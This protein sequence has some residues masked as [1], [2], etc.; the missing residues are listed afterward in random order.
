LRKGMSFFY[1]FVITATLFV[2]YLGSEIVSVMAENTPVKRAHCIILDAGH[3]GVDGGT[4]SCDGKLESA[5]NLEITLRLNS[6][7]NF[8][9]HETVMIRTSDVSV[10]TKGETIA[11]KKVSDLRERVRIVNETKNAVLL[12]IHQNYFSDSRYRGAQVFYADTDGSRELA[13]FLQSNLI[14]TVNPGST[15]MSKKSSGIYLMEHIRQ[16]G[17]LI[18]CGFLS[19]AEESYKLSTPEYQKQLCSVIAASVSSFLSNT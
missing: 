17:V 3:G 15:R 1:C 7:L 9:G 16:P 12:S 5:Y 11:Q 6:L 13:K 10:Y 4:I 2:A 19:N 18:E 8:L 14:S